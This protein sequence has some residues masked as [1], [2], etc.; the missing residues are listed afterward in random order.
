MKAQFFSGGG[1]LFSGRRVS[2]LFLGVLLVGMWG[3]F[4]SPR[5]ASADTVFSLDG[6]GEPLI[7]SDVRAW[8]MG[9]AAM[10]LGDGR[11]Y[12]VLNPATARVRE[13]AVLSVT[14]APGFLR[15]TGPDAVLHREGFALDLAHLLFPQAGNGTLSLSL[16]RLASFNTP[17]IES[18][19][20]IDGNVYRR[21]AQSS[22]SLS[23]AGVGYSVDWG[24]WSLGGRADYLFGSAR[25][26]WIVAFEADTLFYDSS[27]RAVSIRDQVDQQSTSILGAGISFGLLYRGEISVGATLNWSP[28]AEGHATTAGLASGLSESQAVDYEL[29]LRIGVGGAW[30]PGPRLTCVI[31]GEWSRWSKFRYDG[32]YPDDIRD[33][34]RLAGGIE[35]YAGAAG[36]FLEHHLPLR[37]GAAYTPLPYAA[38]E[39]GGGRSRVAKGLLTLGSGTSFSKGRGWIDVAFEYGFR[40]HAAI[41]E[42]EFRL[43]ISISAVE[44]WSRK[45]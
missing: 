20:A 32:E 37:L 22:G 34:Y 11:S 28:W 26:E 23:A 29:P 9:G 21:S 24:N 3:R 16:H 14:A 5:P 38:R 18:Q 30:Q 15:T 6:V 27:G 40:S 36:T 41:Q 44:K 43:H 31:D 17:R 35:W 7:G 42:Q 39:T 19:L 12:S 33:S 25:E 4:G 13:Q 10:A 2:P 45:F 1:G 8:G